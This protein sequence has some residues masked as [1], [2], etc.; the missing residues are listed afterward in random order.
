MSST[1]DLILV[2]V[3]DH[4][5]EP[6]TMFEGR[7]PSKF[8]D[9]APRVS[10]ADGQ[11]FW[12]FDG[13]KIANIG[14]NAVAGLPLDEY[15]ADPKAFADM[16]PGCYDVHERVRDMSANG[17]LGSMCFPSFAQFCGQRFARAK[18]K[19]LA[20]SLVQAYNDWHLEEWCGPYPDRFIPL[21]LLPL[22]DPDLIAAEVRRMAL[23]GCHA[24]AFSENP[25]SLGYPS[26]HSAHWDPL[27][28]ACTETGTVVCMHLGSSSKLAS[29]ADDAPINVQMT[30][31]PINM[32]MAASDL[33]WS[34]I[35]RRWPDVR[36]A[37]SEGGI[38]WI[39]YFL[40]RIDYVFQHN[41]VWTGQDFGGQLPSEVFRGRVLACFIDDR[42]GLRLRDTIGIDN[43]AWECDYPHSDSTW[44]QSAETLLS[45]LGDLTTSDVDKITHQNAMRWF[46]FEPF[47]RR[48][49]DQSSVAALQAEA[50]SVD[51][52]LQSR[53]KS[54]QRA[55]TITSG[56]YARLTGRAL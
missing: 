30:L 34:P 47:G 50:H 22:W 53:G 43:I 9:L 46:Q 7:L 6:P 26:L 2:S 18:D 8:R 56:E 36:F 35:F 20:L 5:I 3:D 39:P 28:R 38:G 15:G 51:V 17:V 44:P 29:T 16:R 25:A 10:S 13:Q 4:V 52:S 31:Q 45:S 40:E 41:G 14:L 12:I 1:N 19:D 23:R 21:A 54:T 33:I 48:S 49:A 37:L 32:V 24:V 27:W 11:D 42:A 55:T